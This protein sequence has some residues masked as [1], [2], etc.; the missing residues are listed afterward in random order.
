MSEQVPYTRRHLE[1]QAAEYY[2]SI[3]KPE[4]EWKSVEDLTPQLS[5][6]RHQVYGGDFEGA[7]QTLQTID[8]DYLYLWGHYTLLTDLHSELLGNLQNTHLVVDNL[9][10]L[11]RACRATGKFTQ[12]VA[13]YEKA[14]DVAKTIDD[15]YRKSVLFGHLGSVHRA[16]GKIKQ[17]VEFYE[18]AL[19]FAPK[20]A[21]R[22]LQSDHLGHLGMCYRS[23]GSMHQAIQYHQQ[24]L[25]L[26]RE[27]GNR[28]LEGANLSGLGS[29][30]RAIG[31]IKNPWITTNKL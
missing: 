27:I 23:L 4:N 9:V 17:A 24:A 26:A 19:A 30:T 29:A 2:A 25:T 8:Y 5:Q 3:R 28:A 11:G 21:D 14:L 15:P 1:L 13:Y 20:I 18:Q 16:L 10:G 31:K 7:S 22:S 6:F 12:A